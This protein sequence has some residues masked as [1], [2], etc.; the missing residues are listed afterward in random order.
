MELDTDIL[1]GSALSWFHYWLCQNHPLSFLTKCEQRKN[2]EGS[3]RVCAWDVSLY[4]ENHCIQ[5][6]QTEVSSLWSSRFSVLWWL[7]LLKAEWMMCEQISG[8]YCWLIKLRFGNLKQLR[9]TSTVQL[10]RAVTKV[11][12]D[13]FHSRLFSLSSPICCWHSR[14]QLVPETCVPSANPAQV[15]EIPW[16][17]KWVPDTH[18]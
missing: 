5:S 16:G 7:L 11:Q 15:S 2:P 18:V 1:H 9:T 6:F 4:S 8:F 13:Q 3:H 17:D 12:R 10:L 14:K